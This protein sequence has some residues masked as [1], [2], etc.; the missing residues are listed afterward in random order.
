MSALHLYPLVFTCTN[1]LVR[2]EEEEEIVSSES[3]SWKRGERVREE[4]GRRGRR[5][6][7]GEEVGGK[8][9]L[10]AEEAETAAVR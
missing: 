7:G 2:I 9:G 1:I 10:L 8:V 6:G 3:T 4:I 5:E